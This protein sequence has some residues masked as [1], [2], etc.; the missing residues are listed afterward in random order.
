MQKFLKRLEINRKKKKAWSFPFSRYN[1]E[2][3]LDK[4]FFNAKFIYCALRLRSAHVV[5]V[6]T[7]ICLKWS[8]NDVGFGSAQRTAV[9]LCYNDLFKWSWN[10]VRFGSAQRTVVGVV[11]N[12][13]F[14]MG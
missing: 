10:E 4:I 13:L 9:G 2:T 6:G 12:D 11:C 14:K 3:K 5:D 7:M 8:D 1:P